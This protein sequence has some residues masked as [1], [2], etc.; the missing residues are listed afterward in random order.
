MQN[1]AGER[2]LTWACCW[3][4]WPGATTSGQGFF[5]LLCSSLYSVSPQ[6]VPCSSWASLLFLSV[7][8][9]LLC[10]GFFLFLFFGFL[11]FCPPCSLP[12]FFFYRVKIRSLSPRIHISLPGCSAFDGLKASTV[13]P[14]LVCWWSLSS[15]LGRVVGVKVTGLNPRG[16]VGRQCGLEFGLCV[17]IDLLWPEPFSVASPTRFHLF[18]LRK[19]RAQCLEQRR[20]RLGLSLFTLPFKV[21]VLSVSIKIVSQIY[22]SI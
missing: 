20:F 2:R 13:L 17:V 7:L 3:S 19:R 12:S 1:R 10:S 5:F 21:S 4:W 8:Y 9:S 18:F 11:S 6:F 22:N 15:R 14:L 16:S